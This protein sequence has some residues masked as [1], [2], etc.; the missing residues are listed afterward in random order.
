MPGIFAWLLRKGSASVK[1]AG[2]MTVRDEVDVLPINI[3]YHRSI[4]VSEFWIID[5]GSTDGTT[6]LLRSMAEHQDWLH[7]R[8]EPGPFHQ[9]E[10]ASDLAQEAHRSDSD[11]V[12]PIDADEFWWTS[13][14]SLVGGLDEA[15]VGA[16]NCGLQNFVQAR[17]VKRDHS[18]SLMTMTHRA[19]TRG[20][21]ADA[22]RL[23]E[24]EEIGFVEMTYPPKMI[25]RSSPGLVIGQGNHDA[26]GG[27]ITIPYCQ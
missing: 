1:I 23:V 27:Q 19:Q 15:G 21:A 2:V 18:G 3:A 25:L 4:G 14:D 10:F 7:W 22:R 6:D 16:Y 5:N 20:T 13:Y 24:S 9:S 17:R 12:V 8:S 11:W 26:T